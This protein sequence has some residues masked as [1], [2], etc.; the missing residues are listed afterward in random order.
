M[1]I[2]SCVVLYPSGWVLIKNDIMIKRNSEINNDVSDLS[3]LSTPTF[4]WM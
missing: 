4:A 1:N 3:T 2:G